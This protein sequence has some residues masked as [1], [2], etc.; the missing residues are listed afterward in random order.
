MQQVEQGFGQYVKG[1]SITKVYLLCIRVLF[2]FL[3]FKKIREKIVDKID[4][5]INQQ[6][7]TEKVP[8]IR[9]EYSDDFCACS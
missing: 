7:D 6:P 2:L 5:L 1:L 3:L 9:D 4:T 8:S